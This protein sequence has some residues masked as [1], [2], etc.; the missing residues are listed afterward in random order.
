MKQR[1]FVGSQSYR[2]ILSTYCVLWAL[3]LAYSR[4]SV[5]AR[6]NASEEKVK[7]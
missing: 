7:F 5:R 3:Y 1:S 2:N 6:P 4:Y